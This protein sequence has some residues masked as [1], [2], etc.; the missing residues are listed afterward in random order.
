[1]RISD[2]SSDVC[3]S[4]LFTSSMQFSH[5]S[6]PWAHEPGGIG[7]GAELVSKLEKAARRRGVRILTSTRAR[8]LVRNEKGRVVGVEVSQADDT[9]VLRA[10]KA[11]VLTRCGLT[12][13]PELIEHYGRP[14]PQPTPPP[15]GARSMGDPKRS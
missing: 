13:N 12:R 11:V 14:R 4:D 9:R 1:M 10:H 8:R 3:S 5:M 15:P 7:G 6:E 2:W